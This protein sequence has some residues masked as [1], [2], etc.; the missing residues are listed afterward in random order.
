MSPP[1]V[2][3]Q[4]SVPKIDVMFLKLKEAKRQVLLVYFLGY[5]YFNRSGSI[6]PSMVVKKIVIMKVGSSGCGLI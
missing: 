5:D 4:H 1:I 6:T 2:A 3:N